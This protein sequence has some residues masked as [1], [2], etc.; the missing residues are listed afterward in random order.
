MK[1]AEV[2]IGRP[3]FATMMILSLVVLGLFSYGRLGVDQYPNVEFPFS[4]VTTA[5]PGAGPEEIET[6]VTKPIEEAVNTISGIEM[7]RSTSY[8]GLSQVM[9]QFALEKDADVAT[10]E[11]RDA[12]SR[13]LS[14]LPDGTDPPVVQKLD[15]GS[16]PVLTLAVSGEMPLR[17]LTLLARKKV[18]ET[19][20]TTQG[21]GKIT[22]VGG[23]ERQIR[24]VVDPGA[25]RARGLSVQQVWGA[26]KEQNVELPGGRVENGGREWVLRTLGRVD[27]PRRF[28][29]VTVANVAGAPIRIRDVARVEDSEE[30]ARTMARLDGRRVV[31]LTV[32][33]QSGSNT[34]AVIRDVKERLKEIGP[35]LPAG[36]RVEV[37]QDQSAFIIASVRTVEEHI[38]LGAILASL[39][40]LLFMGDLRGTVIASLAIPASVLPAFLLMDGAG[41]SLNMMTLLAL[42]LAVGVVIDDAIVVLENIFRHMEEKNEPAPAAARGA[43]AEIGMAVMATTLSLV[44]IFVPMAYM[45]GIVGRFLKS[46]GLTVAFAILV[47]LFVA[48]SLTPMLCSR[49]LKVSHE[50]NRLQRFVDALNEVLKRRYGR[51]V[52][53]SLAHRKTVAAISVVVMV[54]SIPLAMIIGK[55]FIPPDDR[56]EFNVHVK[57]PEGTGIGVSDDILRQVE[58][59]IR[60]VPEVRSVLASIGEEQ[61]AG[62]NEGKLFVRLTPAEDRSLKQWEVMALVRRALA[63]YTG[64]QTS[65][66][67]ADGFKGMRN[68]D[69]EYVLSGPDLGRLAE[70]SGKIVED[71]RRV[72]GL[73][74][75]DTSLTFKKPEF[76]VRIN[77]DRAQDL[78]VRVQDVASTLRLFVSGEEDVTKYKEG[79]EMFS[80]RLRVGPGG[81]RDAATVGA[82]TIPSSRGGLVRLDS[83]ADIVEARG[84]SQIERF[85]R[86]RQVTI[87]GNLDGLPLGSALDAADRAVKRLRLAPGY[88][89]SV[90]GKARE[91]GRMMSG[92]FTAFLLSAVFMY[93]ILASQ[94]ESFIHPVTIMLSLPLAIPFALLSLFLTGQ[95]FTIF[96]IMGVFM[97]FGIVKK[98]AILQVDYTNTL[99]DR[100]VARDAAILEANTTRLRPILMTTLVLVAAMIPVA[101][102]RGPGAANRATMAVVIIG[103]QTLCLLIT[104]LITPVAYSL[105][106]DAARGWARWLSHRRG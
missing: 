82:L 63:K 41:F 91:M 73:V 50:R 88:R 55:D 27:S 17:D 31:S 100:G 74:D 94:F 72:E 51:M 89:R 20:E 102:G 54:S 13:V 86:Q 93:M 43:T 105:F 97:L 34:V 12:V 104:L 26:L 24:V 36:V 99:R 68:A 65:V 85:N 70:Y 80:V 75:L 98:N 49:F 71:L 39:A 10:Q 56:G 84:P 9:I 58:A 87:F 47:S 18:K 35:G 46:F 37:I 38:V 52:L 14:D 106:D 79:D 7:V 30:E 61:G 21:V 59:D 22:M 1:L 33:K 44:I 76:Q 11:V 77:R 81:R 78:G 8:E 42:T 25:L 2:S 60:R 90:V 83:V 23:R 64:L 92:F 66:A 96:S 67:N 28:E 45:Y 5:L 69:F 40:V 15:V 19:L 6:S 48:F 29:D 4:V 53:W 57:A 101:F 32:Q 95:S 3:V 62:V 16:T 103:G